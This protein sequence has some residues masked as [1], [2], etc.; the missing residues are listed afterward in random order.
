[1]WVRLAGAVV[2]TGLCT[3][4]ADGWSYLKAHTTAEARPADDV[5]ANAETRIEAVEPTAAVSIGPDLGSARRRLS[6]YAATTVFDGFRHN[7]SS[8][9]ARA[10]ARRDHHQSRFLSENLT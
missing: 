8:P 4:T 2:I 7:E 1:M 5:L 9:H 6:P 3:S 10:T